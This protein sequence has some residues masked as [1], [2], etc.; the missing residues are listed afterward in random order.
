MKTMI[1]LFAC[2]LSAFAQAGVQSES[3]NKLYIQWI[4]TGW[5]DNGFVINFDRQITYNG[6]DP[7]CEWPQGVFASM[8]SNMMD[9]ML[10]IALAA[11]MAQKPVKV[12]VDDNCSGSRAK[13]ISIQ[14]LTEE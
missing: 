4:E 2:L 14:I 10:S 8:S 9:Q 13:L 5:E 11:Q 6:T 12:Y 7:G 1:T 3:D